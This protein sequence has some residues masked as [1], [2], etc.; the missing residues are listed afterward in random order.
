MIY[1]VFAYL[2]SK[3]INAA[4]KIIMIGPK[5]AFLSWKL[6]FKEN[7]GDKKDLKVLD[8]HEED[9]AEVQLRL[10]RMGKNLILVNYESLPSIEAAL[11]DIIDQRTVLV[12]DEIHKIKGL[13]RTE[14]NLLNELLR[15][16]FINLH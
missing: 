1:G 7:F 10:N 5:N 4:D 6:E 9:A 12:F 15:N 11:I 2:N 8:I 3:E 13:N 14:H 16:Q